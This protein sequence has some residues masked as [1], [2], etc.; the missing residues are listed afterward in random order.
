MRTDRVTWLG[1]SIFAALLVFA[2][3]ESF[4]QVASVG[5]NP[6]SGKTAPPTAA[7]SQHSASYF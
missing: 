2:A 6:L 5:P 7:P 3:T 1:L 4:G